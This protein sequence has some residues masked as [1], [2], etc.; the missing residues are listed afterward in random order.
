VTPTARSV[1]FVVAVLLSVGCGSAPPPAAEAPTTIA[2]RPGCNAASADAVTAITATLIGDAKRIGEAFVIEENERRYIG[3]N[4]YDAAGKPLSAADVWIIE[5]NKVYAL[6]SGAR[7]HSNAADGREL[8][9]K[10]VAGV[11]PGR[12]VSECVRPA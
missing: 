11:G 3:A 6:S 1:V 10:P 5:R 7:T 12:F 9:D 2:G 4:T 8:P